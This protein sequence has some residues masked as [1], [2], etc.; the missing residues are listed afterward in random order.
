MVERGGEKMM[1]ITSR[2][3]ELHGNC[4]RK[5]SAHFS[6]CLRALMSHEDGQDNHKQQRVC[7]NEGRPKRAYAKGNKPHWGKSPH[8]SGLQRSGLASRR[9]LLDV[10]SLALEVAAGGCRVEHP[11]GGGVG[12]ELFGH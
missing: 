2:R 3:N 6:K 4:G 1:D 11:V 12:G 7:L 8:N 5:N 9:K 10:D